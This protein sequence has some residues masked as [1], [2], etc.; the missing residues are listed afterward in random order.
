MA[1]MLTIATLTPYLA[2]LE[3]REVPSEVSPLGR[4]GRVYEMVRPGLAA[5]RPARAWFLMSTDEPPKLPPS[6]SKSRFWTP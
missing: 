2:A 6:M 4:T 3:R 5:W 1:M